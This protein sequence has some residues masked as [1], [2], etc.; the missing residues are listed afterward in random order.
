M[1]FSIAVFGDN[2]YSRLLPFLEKE[3]EQ[4]YE[5]IS[6]YVLTKTTTTIV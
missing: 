5:K 6:H 4:Q 1:H 2:S 3:W